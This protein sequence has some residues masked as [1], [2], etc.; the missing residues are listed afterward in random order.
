MTVSRNAL[1]GLY[2][3][4]AALALLGTW[5]H[6]VAYLGGGFIDVNRQFWSDTFANPAS[7][8]ITVDLF[9]LSLAVSLWMVTEARRLQMRGVWLYL[10]FG[11]LI[12]ISVTVPAFMIHRQRALAA[13]APGTPAG[14]LRRGDVI[15]I[16]ALCIGVAAYTLLSFARD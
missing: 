6:N 11:L 3:V 10:L 7:R 8:S 9:F 2:G 12:A 14:H 16:V 4:I 1:C 5:T 13:R 15:G